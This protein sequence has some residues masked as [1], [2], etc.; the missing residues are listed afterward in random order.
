M[1]PIKGLYEIAIRVKDLARAEA[2]YKDLLGLKEGLRDDRRNWVFLYVG[3]DAGM[4]VLQEDKADWPAQH[5]AF[6]VSEEDLGQAAAMLKEQGVTV[7]EPVYHEWMN[8]VSVYFDD[9][10][11]HALELIALSGAKKAV[12]KAAMQP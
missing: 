8:S 4:V 3:G 2:F 7:S 12:Q 9:P 10:D 6:T 11:G 5:F 1:L